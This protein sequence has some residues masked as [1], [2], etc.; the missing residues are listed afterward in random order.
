MCMQIIFYTV[1][2]YYTGSSEDVNTNESVA[3]K[4]EYLMV[5]SQM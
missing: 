2:D 1:C 3:S 4:G 5:E